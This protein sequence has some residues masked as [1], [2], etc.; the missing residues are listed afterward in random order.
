M[1]ELL[2]KICNK[3]KRALLKIQGD[4]EMSGFELHMWEESLRK[5]LFNDEK[6]INNHALKDALEFEDRIKY[7]E[8]F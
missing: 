6:N 7:Q 3:L 4:N 2:I 8:V 5:L 1:I